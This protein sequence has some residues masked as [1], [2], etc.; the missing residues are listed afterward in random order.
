MG[1]TIYAVARDPRFLTDALAVAREYWEASGRHAAANGAVMRTSV[2][3][4]WEYVDAARVRHNAERACLLPHADPRC[5]GSCV[6]VCLAIRALVLG[7]QDVSALTS[8]MSAEVAH[9]HPEMTHFFTLTAE[10]TLEVF[11]LDEGMERGVEG[12]RIGYTLKA[13]GAAF[14]ALQNAET[15]SDGLLTVIHEGGD[16]DTNA[17]VAGALLGARFGFEAIPQEWRAGLVFYRELLERA[18]QLIALQDARSAGNG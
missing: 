3:G 7:A 16:A 2:L 15:F 6:A 12:N 1:R 9:F 18:E 4:V 8:A 10:P 11:D 13:L 5:I 17:A 14:W